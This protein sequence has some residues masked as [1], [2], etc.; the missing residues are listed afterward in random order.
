MNSILKKIIN[1]KFNSWVL[2]MNLNL[3]LKYNFTSMQEAWTWKKFIA[4]NLVKNSSSD[5]NI[6]LTHPNQNLSDLLIEESQYKLYGKQ[7]G[8]G[9][10]KK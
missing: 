9:T 4:F 3:T 1:P 2:F 5:K 6:E 8:P 7:S 10:V